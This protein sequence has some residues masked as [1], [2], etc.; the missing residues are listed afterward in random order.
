M[1][2]TNICIYVMKKR[3]ENVLRRFQKELYSGLCISSI[4]LAEL[5]YGMKHSSDPVRNEQALLRFLAPMN[6]LPFGLAAASEYGEIRAYL[7]SQGTPIGPLDMLIAG[8]ARSEGMILVTNN[9]K[10]FERVPDLVLE[11]WAE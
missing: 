11:N 9:G 7:Q 3:P 5:E 8:H 4:T 10:E 1:L 6:I 2:D